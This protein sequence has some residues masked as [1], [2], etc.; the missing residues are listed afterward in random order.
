MLSL[1]VGIYCE[2]F[3]SPDGRGSIVMNNAHVKTSIYTQIK[4]VVVAPIASR[5]GIAGE[6]GAEAGL[7]NVVAEGIAEPA[8]YNNDS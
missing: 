4:S 6:L 1:D 5:M 3:Q 2:K 8:T 7:V